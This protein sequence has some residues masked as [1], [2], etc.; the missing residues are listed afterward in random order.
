MC[1]TN[2][3]VSAEVQIAVICS[4]IEIFT[5][6]SPNGDGVNDYFFIAN[7]EA[8]PKHHLQIFNQWGNL[9]Y[10]TRSYKNDWDGRWNNKLLP[11]GTYY[12][13]LEIEEDQLKNTYRGSVELRR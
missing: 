12:F 13:I 1:N 10:Q 5:G 9:I 3:C 2:G 11:D 6:F 7:I 8:K 4:D